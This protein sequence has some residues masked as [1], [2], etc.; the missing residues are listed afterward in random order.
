VTDSPILLRWRDAVKFEESP[1]SRCYIMR[2][3]VGW[4][5]SEDLEGIILAMD[6]DEDGNL[7]KGFGVPREYVVERI[8]LTPTL[9]PRI[10]SVRVPLR[11]R[12]V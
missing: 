2:E 10:R 4:I 3:T 9:L 8:P 11:H 7:E 1:P 5:V 6:K 12:E